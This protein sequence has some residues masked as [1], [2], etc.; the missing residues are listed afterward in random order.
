VSADADVHVRA[1]AKAVED[2]LFQA[3]YKPAHQEGMRDG[4]WVL[5][6]YLDVV[7]HV[8]KEPTRRFYALERLWGDAPAEDLADE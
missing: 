5:L 1:I 3:G 2:G 6:D 8:F 4:N 7:V